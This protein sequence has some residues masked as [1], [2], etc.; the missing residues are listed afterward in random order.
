MIKR[1]TGLDPAFSAV[2]FLQWRYARFVDIMHTNA[3]ALGSNLNYGHVDFW[4]NGGTYQPGCSTID[5]KSNQFLFVP[6]LICILSFT[7]VC[8]HMR[9]ITL[10]A[11]SVQRANRSTNFLSVNQANGN[12]V[13]SMGLNCPTS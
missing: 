10:F 3:Y 4:P 12:I 2:D 13:I 8:S 1:I 5:R 11:E 7:V 6:M 9:A